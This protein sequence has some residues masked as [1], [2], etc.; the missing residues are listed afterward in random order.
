[1]DFFSEH[2]RGLIGTTIFHTILIVGIVVLK[3]VG[4]WP[5]PP[6]DGILINFGSDEIGAGLIEPVRNELTSSEA[7][8]KIEEQQKEEVIPPAAI[9]ENIPEPDK[10]KAEDLLTQDIEDTPEVKAAKTQEEIEKEKEIE[11]EKERKRLEEEERL[12]KER[13]ENERLAEIERV[14]QVEL[15]RVRQIELERKRKEEEERKKKEEEDRTRKEINDRIKGSLS[16]VGEGKV[17]TKVSEGTLYKGGNQGSVTGSADSKNH[18]TGESQ[19]TEGVDFSLEGRN[20]IG[21]LKKPAF[22]GNESGKVVVTIIVDKFG[23]VISATPGAQ[24]TTTMKQSLWEA[25]KKAAFEVR[26]NKTEDP[27]APN[28][29]GTITYDFALY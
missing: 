21:K 23:K 2:K 29:K 19:G 26:F 9:P 3:L 15:E 16:N 10:T 8:A 7:I 20:P 18:S 25:A 24:K 17:N 5:P 6:E 1:M 22:P 11:A 4:V 14:R 12:E 27:N 13:I 28:Q